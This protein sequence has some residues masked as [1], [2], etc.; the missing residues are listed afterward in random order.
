MLLKIKD[1]GKKEVMVSAALGNVETSTGLTLQGYRQKYRQA[2]KMISNKKI[3]WKRT[4]AADV[5]AIS[6]WRNVVWAL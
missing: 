6:R 1:L 4:T 2:K 5:S 3:V